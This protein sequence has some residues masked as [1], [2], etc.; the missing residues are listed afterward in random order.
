MVWVQRA[1]GANFDVTLLVCAEH[2]LVTTGPYRW[3]CHPMYSVLFLFELAVLLTANW[4]VGG[5]P[6]VALTLIVATRAK[7][8]EAVMLNTFGEAY[9]HYMERTGRFLPRL[10]LR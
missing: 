5:V 7:R 3:V 8:E 10:G 9:R 1:L 2:T 6:L 4:F